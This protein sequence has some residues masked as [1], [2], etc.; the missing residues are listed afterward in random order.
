VNILSFLLSRTALLFNY[1][2]IFAPSL[3]LSGLMLKSTT[4]PHISIPFSENLNIRF[5]L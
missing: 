5:L 2:F 1:L 3:I 4:M